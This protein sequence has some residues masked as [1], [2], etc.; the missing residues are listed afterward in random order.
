M[1]YGSASRRTSRGWG[2]A[3]RGEHM[4]NIGDVTGIGWR[5]DA[6]RRDGVVHAR[7]L[8]A[9]STSLYVDAAGEVL[10]IGEREATPHARAIHGRGLARRGRRGESG[11]GATHP[12]D[13]RG[14]ARRFTRR[15]GLGG[16]ARPRGGPGARRR[17]GRARGGA[18]A[19]APRPL[20]RLGSPRG[21]RRRR[22]RLTA[23]DVHQVRATGGRP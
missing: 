10:W 4:M 19:H 13:R 14:I 11:G 8:A 7:V 20:L 5:A 22:A 23:P 9:L 12:P 21:L 16:P 3:V 18:A 17:A 15:R 6:A 2:P 1:R